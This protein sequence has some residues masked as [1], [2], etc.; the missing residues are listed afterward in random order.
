MGSYKIIILCGRFA[1]AKKCTS[2]IAFSFFPLF[3]KQVTVDPKNHT[4]FVGTVRLRFMRCSY[5]YLPFRVECYGRLMVLLCYYFSRK[6]TAPLANQPT[7][8]PLLTIMEV[9][10]VVV[11]LPQA[12]L[13]FSLNFP[14][15]FGCKQKFH[16]F[17][18]L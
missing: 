9:I 16:M 7:G 4:G 13:F 14:T 11:V 1:A 3:I 2:L 5:F 8:A 18:M 6:F 10:E 12:V 17:D 15:M